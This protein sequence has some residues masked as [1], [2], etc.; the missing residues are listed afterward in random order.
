MKLKGIDKNLLRR[1][2]VAIDEE[3]EN[4]P[5]MFVLRCLRCDAGWQPGYDQDTKRVFRGY[6]H[7]I[8]GCHDK[9]LALIFV[10]LFSV[11]GTQEAGDLK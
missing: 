8:R 2:H 1:K 5:N 10:P 7:C 4:V 3:Y 9:E 11:R 6:W